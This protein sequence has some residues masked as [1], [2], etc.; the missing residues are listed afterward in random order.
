MLKIEGDLVSLNFTKI[1]AEP[2]SIAGYGYLFLRKDY[3]DV[4][5][6]G[7]EDGEEDRVVVEKELL[8]KEKW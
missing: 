5:E 4:P 3:I 6:E 2:R 1:P 7:E 8:M